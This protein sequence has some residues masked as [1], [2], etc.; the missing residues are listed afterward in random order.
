MDTK[1]FLHDLKLLIEQY[2][3]EQDVR[4]TDIDIQWFVS[5]SGINSEIMN[6][7]LDIQKS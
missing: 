7:R 5:A 6:I 4:I 1:Q 2:H 3:R